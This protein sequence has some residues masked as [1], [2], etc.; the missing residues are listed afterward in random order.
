MRY[1]FLFAFT[2]VFFLSGISQQ[3]P[4]QRIN[5]KLLIYHETNRPEKVFLHLDKDRY[6]TGENLWFSAYVVEALDHLPTEFSRVLYAEL[7][8]PQDEILLRRTYKVDSGRVAGQFVIPDSLIS[9]TYSVRAYTNWMRNFDRSFIRPIFVWNPRKPEIQSPLPADKEPDIQFLPEGGQWVAGL[10]QKIAFKAVGS[11][12]RYR[13]LQGEIFNAKGVSISKIQSAHKGM[14]YIQL[15]GES[16]ETYSAR[17]NCEGKSYT[18]QLPKPVESGYTLSVKPNPFTTIVEIQATPDRIPS[19]VYLAGQVRTGLGLLIKVPITE[20]YKSIPIPNNRFLPGV[21]QITL[22]DDQGRPLAER[23]CFIPRKE[24]LKLQLSAASTRFGSKERVDLDLKANDEKGNPAA[25]D[26]SFSAAHLFTLDTA[27]SEQENIQTYLLLSSDLIKGRIEDPTFYF[28]DDTQERLDSLDL[29][30]LTQGWRTF[31][32][33]EIQREEPY[34]Y[35]YPVEQILTL[36]GFAYN[37]FNKPLKEANLNLAVG[38]MEALYTTTTD[39]K[40]RFSFEGVDFTDTT[41]L[42][43]QARNEKNKE[44]YFTIQ[45]DSMISPEVTS[46]EF[47]YAPEKNEY[48]DVLIQSLSQVRFLRYTEGIA[49]YELESVSIQAKKSEKKTNPYNKLHS[50]ATHTL[51]GDQLRVYGINLIESLKGRFPGVTIQGGPGNYKISIRGSTTISGALA[52]NYILDGMFVDIS[53]LEN[54]PLNDVAEIDIIT[55][56]AAS[57]YG[58]GAGDG[59][60]AVYTK[61]GDEYVAPEEEESG[62][63]R[64]KGRG[65]YPVR[66]FYSPN[67]S[68]PSLAPKAKDTRTTLYWNPRVTIDASGNGRLTFYT[69]DLKGTYLM[70][71]QGMTRGGRPGYTELEIVVE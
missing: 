10:N 58:T 22:L 41:R 43:L 21:G 26:L 36:S 34:T 62:V 11:D 47:Q 52:V 12:G 69:G 70:V 61:R 30:M 9:A 17:V 44:G 4:A 15:R 57:I 45:L 28:K 50:N 13:E 32:W 33:K 51:K 65:Y 35:K 6:V 53:V 20:S 42:F 38:K 7:I 1:L 59:I 18:I 14:G 29:L 66:S 60:I 24:S 49:D 40:G 48:E 39:E 68:D 25:A 23:V 5:E 56:P 31:D 46:W 55:G 37:A 19:T 54:T 2:A 16:G 64:P 8:G 67:Y 27:I 63:V 3:N 71:L